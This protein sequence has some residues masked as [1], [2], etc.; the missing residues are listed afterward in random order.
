[1]VK[2][3]G[4]LQQQVQLVKDGYYKLMKTAES[5]MSHAYQL[6][7][8]K[9]DGAMRLLKQNYPESLNKHNRQKLE[10]LKRYCTD[11]IKI[12]LA[13]EYSISCKN[14]S[15]S[16]S[17]LLNYTALAPAKENELL[18]I[19]A[20]FISQESNPEPGSN[21]ADEPTEKK[22]PRTVKL[23][24]SSK[25]MTVQKYKALLTNQLTLLAAANRMKRLSLK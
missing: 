5:G 7:E 25:V 16:L 11:R 19:Q 1:M 18:I 2:N 22:K 4:G 17:D 24:I 21:G 10:E 23:L 12:N 15:Y 20:S 6:L 13:L 9:V 8:G 3:L 14:S